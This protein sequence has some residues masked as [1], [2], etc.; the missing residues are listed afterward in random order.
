VSDPVLREQIRDFIHQEA[1]HTKV[2]ADCNA[3]LARDNPN[4]A[5]VTRMSEVVFNALDRTPRAFR[6]SITTAIEHFTAI[7]ADTLFRYQDDFR[8]TFPAPV[9]DMWLWHAAEETE[10]KGVCFDLHR[11]VV[12]GGMLAYVNRIVGMVVATVVFVGGMIL[13]AAVL[14]RGQPRPKLTEEEREKVR[15]KPF[16]ALNMIG[17]FRRLVPWRLYFGYYRPSFHP[18]AHDNAHFVKEWRERYPGFGLA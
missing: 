6:L 3:A 2:H 14:A 17:L 1:M 8:R 13:A 18:W 10:H 5:R 7:A 12:G 11:A 15:G 9:V 16:V 4:C